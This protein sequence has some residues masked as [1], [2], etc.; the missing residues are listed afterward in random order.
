MVV[1]S[2]VSTLRKK[3]YKMK[4]LEMIKAF[5]KLEGVELTLSDG[6]YYT[7]EEECNGWVAMTEYNPI[8]D[9]ALNCA[10][11]DKYETDIEWYYESVSMQSEYT[12]RPNEFIVRFS[13]KEE[14]PKALIE[15]ILK[16]EGL[17]K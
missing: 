10:A 5:A 16:S 13:G 14:L 3:D 17:W 12:D 15:C 7:K 1:N 6:K 9:L 11:R 4:E 2:S 8:T